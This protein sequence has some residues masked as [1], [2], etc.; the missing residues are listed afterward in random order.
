MRELVFVVDKLMALV[1]GAFMLRLLLQLTRADFRNPVAQAI[2][3]LTNPLVLPLRRLLPAM[4][5]IDTA[6][7]VAVLLVQIV[8]TA[9]VTALSGAGV[10]GAAF[11]LTAAAIRLV[12]LIL[13]LYFF[14]IFAYVL[15]SWVSTDGYSPLGRVLHDL[16]EPVMAP[17]R[18]AVPVLGGLDVS[19]A[20][21]LILIAVLRMILNDRIAPALVGV[22]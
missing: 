5:R 6:S 12:D 11:L 1:V 22:L 8:H 7:V 3:S 19:P 10:P 14:A 20:V 13:L 4:G 17:F 16:C 2:V 15:L 21:V 18:R 9:L